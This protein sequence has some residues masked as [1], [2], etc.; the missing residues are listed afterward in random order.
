[1][2][3]ATHSCSLAVCVSAPVCSRSEDCIKCSIHRLVLPLACSLPVVAGLRCTLHR[4]WC[5]SPPAEHMPA[6][7]PVHWTLLSVHRSERVARRLGRRWCLTRRAPAGTAS[8]GLYRVT[9]RMPVYEWS[10]GAVPGLVCVCVCVCGCGCGCGCVC[11]CAC[12]NVTADVVCVG[13]V[14]AWVYS[15]G[16]CST[17]ADEPHS[18][19]RCDF[20]WNFFIRE[21]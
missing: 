19:I 1:M 4:D 3:Q 7:I 13:T 20:S 5:G 14:F 11:A 6:V 9:V 18:L 10:P 21:L 8:R 16:P 15:A 2:L 17:N 12:V